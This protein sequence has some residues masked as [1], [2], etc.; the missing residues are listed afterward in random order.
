ME[1]IMAQYGNRIA[2]AAVG[3]IAQGLESFFNYDLGKKRTDI[4]MK[5]LEF[6]K[7]AYDLRKKQLEFQM[8][9]AYGYDVSV[10][11][12]VSKTEQGT[13]F[14]PPQGVAAAPVDKSPI[15]V[16][17]SGI[18]QYTKPPGGKSLIG[19][20][21]LPAT[22]AMVQ[23]AKPPTA[24]GK[25]T[26]TPEN[27][28]TTSMEKQNMHIMGS[29]EVNRKMQAVD[30]YDKILTASMKASFGTAAGLTAALARDPAGTAKIIEFN[31]T[32]A[33]RNAKAIDPTFDV[34]DWGM[35]TIAAQTHIPHQL[36]Q[37]VDTSIKR[38]MSIAAFDIIASQNP[39]YAQEWK[40]IRPAYESILQGLQSQKKQLTPAAGA[41]LLKWVSDRTEMYI[42]GK[43]ATPQDSEMAAQLKGQ[44]GGLFF[45]DLPKNDNGGKKA[46]E[47][48][49]SIRDAVETVPELKSNVL[50]YLKRNWPAYFDDSG[51][52]G[53]GAAGGTDDPL[54]I[55]E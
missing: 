54:G 40:R 26:A 42:S 34:S 11:V 23:Y 8:K 29:I 3:S 20:P 49:G 2:G 48:Y 13:R 15:E 41:S 22:G 9:Q 45:K 16:E 51:V 17:M 46:V 31:R 30:L 47:M 24:P 43:V 28:T 44:F 52:K 1:V 5:Q 55:R 19:L 6:Q 14:A 37:Q 50:K 12:P 53:A 21:E 4:Q 36:L 18:R 32:T 35:S 33:G 25:F 39:Q 38:D 7:Q 10:D 27:I